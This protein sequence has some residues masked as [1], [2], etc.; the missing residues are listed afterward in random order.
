MDFLGKFA[1]LLLVL[2]TVSLTVS[3]CSGSEEEQEGGTSATAA[4]R[5]KGRVVILGF[6]GVEPTIVD[7]M[8][9]AG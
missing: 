2:S 8:M 9:E 4:G 7:Q 5:A 3:G 6:D 1:R